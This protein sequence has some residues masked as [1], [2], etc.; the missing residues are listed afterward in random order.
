MLELNDLVR[1]ELMV[2][3]PGWNQKYYVTY[4]VQNYNWLSVD[5]RATMLALC[6]RVKP[7]AFRGDELAARLG[8]AQFDEAESMSDKL[9][10]PSSALVQHRNESTDEVILRLK[11]GFDFQ[12]E[13]F[14][15]F[16]KEAYAAFPK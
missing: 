14:L 13:A 1:D 16:L 5:T 11:E 10:L 6:V 9:N 8:I 3:G 4:R 2:E 12:S 15:A 7:D